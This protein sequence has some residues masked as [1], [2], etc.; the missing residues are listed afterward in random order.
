[1]VVGRRRATVH[2]RPP[3]RGIKR[4]C[5]TPV[6][7]R[8]AAR[9]ARARRAQDGFRYAKPINP[10]RLKTFKYKGLR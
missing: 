5:V 7:G 6:T 10:P 3:G 9:T 8:Q 1:M 4:F 2:G